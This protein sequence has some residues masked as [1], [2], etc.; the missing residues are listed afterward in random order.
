MRV[1]MT[2]ATGLIGKEIGKRLVENGH[3]VTAL[4]RDP[5]T[6]RKSLPFPAQL[7][8]W[9]AGDAVPSIAMNGVEGI[10][11]LAGESIAGGRWTPERKKKM[12]T[13]ESTRLA[14]SSKHRRELEFLLADQ[15]PVSTETAETKR[16]MRLQVKAMAFS[17]MSST[18]GKQSWR[19]S[20]AEWR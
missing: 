9:N 15:R 10:V 19:R 1:L 13:Q 17:Q 5:E 7:V 12:L 20:N 18:S 6:A 2:G 8:K 14:L 4:V 11:N 16:S 3:T